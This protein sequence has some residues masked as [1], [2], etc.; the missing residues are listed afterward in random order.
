[1][2]ENLHCIALRTVKYDDRRSILTAWSLEYGRVSLIVPAGAG[3]EARRRRALMM[4]LGLFEGEADIRPGRELLNIRDVRPMAVNQGILSEPIKGMVAM[5]VAEVLERVLREAA[6]DH[7]LSAFLFDAVDR[8][9]ALPMGAA[10]ANYPVLFLYKLAD[11]LGIVPDV[12]Q[13]RPGAWFDMVHG[14]FHTSMPTGT[15]VLN[16]AETAV[17]RLLSRMTYSTSGRL[18]LP[19]AMRR[20]ALSAMLDY[21]SMHLTSM[22]GLK[23]LE[24][25]QTVME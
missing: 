10:T 1:M 21:Y 25:A 13:W 18:R 6:P 4:P 24:V 14:T 2:Y 22:S 11:N 16:P 15:R 19:L 8:L 9:D 5:F 23:T 7:H 12:E 17:I 3:R 20:Q